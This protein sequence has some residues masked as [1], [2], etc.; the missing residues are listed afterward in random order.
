MRALRQRDRCAGCRRFLPTG[1]AGRCGRCL[2]RTPPAM[3]LRVNGQLVEYPR[4]VVDAMPTGL[5]LALERSQVR[6]ETR[7]TGAG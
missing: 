3:A 7:P 2:T 5:R 6:V 4:A 1:S